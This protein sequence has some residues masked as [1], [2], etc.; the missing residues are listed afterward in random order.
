LADSGLRTRFLVDS[1]DSGWRS[2]GLVAVL[3]EGFAGKKNGFFA[4]IRG[5]CARIAR[6][7][8]AVTALLATAIV[9][10]PKFAA[11][12]RSILRG[13]KISPARAALLTAAAMTAAAATSP[14][15]AAA[16]TAPTVI[17][18]LAVVSGAARIILSGVKARREI[19]RRRSIGIG[20]TLFDRFRALLGG[21]LLGSGLLLGVPG[22]LTGRGRG[23]LRRYRFVFRGRL[24][25]ELLAMR[26]LLTLGGA[27]ERLAGK[28]LDARAV[29][30]SY[31][32]SGQMLVRLLVWL[33]MLV[34]L[35]VFE[36]VADVEK[37]V[38][39]EADVHESGLHAREHARNFSLVDAANESE[40][41]FPLDVNFD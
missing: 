13:R 5:R 16:I 24:R 29:A 35:E 41:F 18:A 6:A 10:A 9:I 19:L 12:R 30:L 8:L 11:L 31:C 26:L 23:V 32:G 33:A 34:I 15:S 7:F 25:M 40:F 21:Q 36:N 28:Q 27:S 37:R 17:L 38:A 22:C 2:Y 14:A 39:V 20:L 1:R 4:E 3:C